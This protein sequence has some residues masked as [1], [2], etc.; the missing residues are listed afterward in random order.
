MRAYRSERTRVDSTSGDGTGGFDQRYVDRKRLSITTE[1]EA[2]GRR[3]LRFFC[4]GLV[5]DLGQIDPC[6][7]LQAYDGLGSG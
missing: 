4:V 5:G 6:A 1:A 2:C 3:H 7:I